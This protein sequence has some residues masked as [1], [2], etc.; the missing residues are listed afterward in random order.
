MS[1]PR[2]S[3]RSGFTIVEVVLAMGILLIGATAIIAF[4]T[5]GSATA[6]HAQLRTQAAAAIEA[7]EADIDHHLFPLED[8]VLGEPVELTDRPV[9]GV[10]GVLY[11]ARATPN[12]ELEREYRVDVSMTWESGGMKRSKDWTMIRIRELT[13]GERLRRE[14]IEKSGGFQRRPA[15]GA[16]EANQ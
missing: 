2:T 3:R 16:G 6:R 11:T 8:G 1:T 14:F 9:P 7:V 5:F 12:P 10:P 13:F 4:L 15:A